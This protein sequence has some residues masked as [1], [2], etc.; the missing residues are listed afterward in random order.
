MTALPAILLD[1]IGSMLLPWR[2]LPDYSPLYA[3]AGVWTL[4]YGLAGLRDWD[5]R[6]T[7]S[8][9]RPQAATSFR[10]PLRI[11]ERRLVVDITCESVTNT[12]EEGDDLTIWHEDQEVALSRRNPSSV[13][14]LNETEDA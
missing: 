7:F 14:P 9:K 3:G 11:R 2:L 13:F 4:V 12:L 10:F 1:S 8:P 5:G 6:I